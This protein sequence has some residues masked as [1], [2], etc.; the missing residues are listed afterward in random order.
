MKKKNKENFCIKC[1]HAKISSWKKEVIG[2]LHPKFVK[3]DYIN[4]GIES[5]CWVNV[6]G[7]HFFNCK[8]KA[9][10]KYYEP[11]EEKCQN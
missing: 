4:G 7:I 6:R 3:I 10:C 1:K 5:A 9:Y 11:A 2:C 8:K